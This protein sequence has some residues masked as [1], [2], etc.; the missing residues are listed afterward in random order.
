[1]SAQVRPRIQPS[2]EFFD[3]KIVGRETVRWLAFAG[4]VIV[5]QRKKQIDWLQVGGE[6]TNSPCLQKYGRGFIPRGLSAYV[7]MGADH[8]PQE[9]LQNVGGGVWQGMSVNG[10]EVKSSLP[11]IPAYPADS[12][13][14][15]LNRS[16]NDAGSGGISKG[17]VELQSL[18]GRKWAECHSADFKSGILDIIENSF[19]GDGIEPTLR[20]FRE[21]IRRGKVSETLPI[22]VGKF[23]DEW[24]LSCE[25]FSLWGLSKLDL[26]HTQL[27]QGTHPQGHV[28]TYSPLAR[29][30]LAQL[31]VQ[32]QDQP[33]AELARMTGDIGRSVASA[34]ETREPSG[35]S[36]IDLDMIDRRFEERIESRLASAREVDAK[37][38]ADL[39]A[40]LAAKSPDYDLT[41]ERP[42]GVHPQTWK[43]L[44]REAGLEE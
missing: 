17:I 39:E 3:T 28:Y 25:E 7:E 6:E 12:V 16:R 9:Q 34:M 24:L 4:D 1:M 44:K 41:G 14:N 13:S 18:V 26:E 10:Q 11:Y 35:M 43:R 19:F 29:V 36:A 21:Q 8:M 38:I 15:I 33:F 30:L 32:P 31:E 37:R 23:K 40:Q 22:D 20:G 27:K 2:V 5:P 42:E